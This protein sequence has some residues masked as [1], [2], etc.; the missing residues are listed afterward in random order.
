MFTGIVEDR[1]V[2]TSVTGTDEG[3]R[4]QVTTALAATLAIGDSLAVNGV[5]LTA[6]ELSGQSCAFEVVPETLSRTNLGAAAPGDHVNLERSMPAD[7]R[8]DGHIVQGHVDGRGTVVA[9]AA[10]GEGTRLAVSVE[11]SLSRYLVEKGSITINGVSLTVAALTDD[12]FEVALI[13]HTL[14][15][16]NLGDLSKGDTVN[17]EADVIAKYVERIMERRV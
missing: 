12:G 1:G 16:T 15:V 6:V 10:E 3:A 13:P 8:F 4:I 11:S 7:G 9:V 2:V 17:L 14:G 5:C